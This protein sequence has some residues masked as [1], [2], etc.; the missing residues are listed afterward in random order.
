MVLRDESKVDQTGLDARDEVKGT[1]STAGQ[2]QIILGSGIVNEVYKEFIKMAG[3][4]AIAKK[5]SKQPA[6]KN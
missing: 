5:K 6:R 1:F 4:D 3:I 2:Y